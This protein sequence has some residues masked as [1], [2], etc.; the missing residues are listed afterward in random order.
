MKFGSTA[1]PQQVEAMGHVVA[2]YCKHV[3]V[4]PG[5]PEEEHIASLVLAL[6]E[7]GVR[8][9]NELLRAMIVPDNRL[10]G[11]TPGARAPTPYADRGKAG[12]QA[13]Q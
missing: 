1:N 6:H 4:D 9:E 5:T 10:P 12:A 3:G 8:G 13:R 7:V 2:A 11:A